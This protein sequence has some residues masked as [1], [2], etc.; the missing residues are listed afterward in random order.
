MMDDVINHGVIKHGGMKH[1]FKLVA[2]ALLAVLASPVA[3]LADEFRPA[4]LEITEREGSAPA[5]RSS[6]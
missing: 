2:C 1:R 4:L 3:L 5:S 6:S